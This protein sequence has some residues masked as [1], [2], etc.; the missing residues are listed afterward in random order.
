MPQLSEIVHISKRRE[1]RKDRVVPWAEFEPYLNQLRVALNS[2]TQDDTFR[3]VGYG[4]G[5]M[6]SSWRRDGA[7]VVALNAFRWA[8]HELG[9]APKAGTAPRP[10]A[11]TTDDLGHLLSATLGNPP[12][13]AERAALVRKIAAELAR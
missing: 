8:L 13:D 3:H 6:V 4:G 12:R 10:S 2:T 1:S 11:F 7:P 9:Q 5:S